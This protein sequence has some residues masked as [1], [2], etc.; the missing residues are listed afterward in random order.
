M[1]VFVTFETEEANKRFLANCEAKTNFRYK[2]NFS[3][4]KHPFVFLGEKTEVIA[5]VEPSNINWEKLGMIK[6]QRFYDWLSKTLFTAMI[7]FA[8]IILLSLI[9]NRIISGLTY[10]KDQ[11]C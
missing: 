11:D 2:V 9:K 10:R 3:N 7:M 5:S 6:S 4:T 1:A 8:A